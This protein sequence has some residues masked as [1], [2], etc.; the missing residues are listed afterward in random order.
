MTPDLATLLFGRL[1]PA[2]RGTL[3][4]CATVGRFDAGL[5]ERRLRGDGRDLSELVNDGRVQALSGPG[6]RYRL[7]PSLRVCGWNQW[8]VDEGLSPGVAQVPRALAGLARELAGFYRDVDALEELRQLVVCDPVRAGERFRSLYAEADRDFDLVRCQDLVDALAAS[9]RAHLVPIELARERDAYQVRLTARGQWSTAYHQSGRYLAR[10]ALE[11][12]LIALTGDDGTRVLQLYATGGMGKTMELRWFVARYCVTGDPL[13][14]C[15][16]IDFDAIDP[17]NAV[18]YP[19]LLLLEIAG[20]LNPQIA[21]SPFQELLRDHERYR[22][23]LSRTAI[24]DTALLGEV[25]SAAAD[26]EDIT[27]RFLAALAEARGVDRAVVVFDTLEEVILRPV[28]DPGVVVGLL[29]RLHD[30][31]STLRLVLSGRYDVRERLA[32]FAEAFPEAESLRVRPFDEEEARRYL[33]SRG[34][35]Q[36]A[37]ATAMIRKSGGL[38]FSLALF[39]DLAQ[40]NPGLTPLEVDQAEGLALLYCLDRILERIPDDRIRWLLRYGVV[41]RRLDLDFVVRVLPPFL[42]RGMSGDAPDDDPETDDRPPRKTKIFLTSAEPGGLALRDLWAELTRYASAYSWV[43]E[44]APGVLMFH[45]NLRG[46]V[47]AFLRDHDV[48]ARLHAAAADYFGARREAEPALWSRWTREMIYHMLHVWGPEALALWRG[49]LETA[50][51]LGRDDVAGELAADLLSGD[52]QDLDGEPLPDLV[53]HKAWYEAHVELAR[54]AVAQARGQSAAGAAGASWSAAESSLAAASLLLA[55]HPEIGRASPDHLVADAC[56]HVV[57]GRREQAASQIE[58]AYQEGMPLAAEPDALMVLADLGDRE[59]LRRAYDRATEL[60]RRAGTERGTGDPTQAVERGLAAAMAYVALRLGDTEAAE[61]RLSSALSWYE[62]AGRDG[63]PARAET[64]IRLGRP[65]DAVEAVIPATS[66]VPVAAPLESP[67]PSTRRREG[68]LTAAEAMLM[69]RRPQDALRLLEQFGLGDTVQAAIIAAR[70]H[71]DLL[72]T[73]EGLLE[74]ARRSEVLDAEYAALTLETLWLHLRKTGNLRLAER[75]VESLWRHPELPA[76]LDLSFRHGRVELLWE[77]DQ[78]DAAREALEEL[79]ERAHDGPP[80]RL[81][82]AGVTGL[83]LGDPSF[84]R[85][86]LRGLREIDEVGARLTLLAGLRRCPSIGDRE[87]ARALAQESLDPWLVERDEVAYADADRAVLDL[88]AA[89]VARLNGR[90]DLSR[91]LLFEGT[92]VLGEYTPLVWLDWIEAMDRLGAARHDEAEPPTTFAPRHRGHREFDAAYLIAL[93]RR[94]LPVDPHEVTAR[95][96]RDA[97][98]LLADS[99]VKTARHAELHEGMCELALA[100]GRREAARGAAVSAQ[101][102]W[103][104]LGRDRRARI[105]RDTLIPGP[106]EPSAP[107]TVVTHAGDELFVRIEVARSEPGAGNGLV[108]R[109]EG[110]GTS[111]TE[112]TPLP[113]WFERGNSANR[114]SVEQLARP[115]EWGRSAGRVLG[116]LAERLGPRPDGKPTDIRLVA[117]TLV[118]APWELTRIPDERLVAFDE[119]RYLY[120]GIGVKDG[121]RVE[122]EAVQRVLARLGLPH[123]EVNRALGHETAADLRDFQSQAKLRD[124]G[125]LR[126]STWRA[127]HTA[128]RTARAGRPPHVLLIQPDQRASVRRQRGL[129]GSVADAEAIYRDHSAR[130]TILENPGR[131]TIERQRDELRLDEPVDVVHVLAAMDNRFKDPGLSFLGEDVDILFPRDLGVLIRS[132]RQDIP[133]LLILD[134]IQ[135]STTG[136]RSRALLQRNDIADQSL[137]LD[138]VWTILAT[139]LADGSARISQMT[140]LA[141]TLVNGEGP[142]EIWRALQAVSNDLPFATTAVFSKLRPDAMFRP[143]MQ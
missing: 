81:V 71:G 51:R 1:P 139:G 48:F 20:Q 70:A 76:D 119:L 36:D 130:L 93:A 44:V 143:G 91:R 46:P 30:S 22:R 54:V 33:A 49:E 105:A 35:T 3:Q 102:L 97:A 24:P 79:V 100:Q 68:V 77:R 29:R 118:A 23:A 104:E 59:S 8:W 109:V 38:P 56:V 120:R 112:L 65:S 19:W 62:R 136:E 142:G 95:R 7:E 72:E 16:W 137:A 73:D 57:R 67:T 101:D 52:Y 47:R 50:R 124:N 111:A 26:A 55:G 63:I 126:R 132:L 107:I 89:E 5:Y 6:E 103:T 83:A 134:A 69:M 85:T 135:P 80:D 10:D 31:A 88:T 125:R 127:L 14:P 45:E 11:R 98:D 27:Q 116:M 41:P 122:A 18:R 96:L 138:G 32:G 86:V 25:A 17:V 106:G 129:R 82:R 115:D 123:D 37:L 39:G 128:L 87:L 66:Q 13:I 40:G 75:Q 94:R 84:T 28:A 90:G 133:P 131:R 140:T 4:R 61:G 34:V 21:E 42:T 99:V 9:D 92:N 78:A 60:D 58:R 64:L 114:V 53:T 141:R 110:T 113:S 12:R 74:A 15:A 108:V 43:T 121:L 117:T 2:E